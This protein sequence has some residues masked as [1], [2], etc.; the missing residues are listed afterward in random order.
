MN[1]F[2]CTDEVASFLSLKYLDK[3]VKVLIFIW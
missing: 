2:I 3:I 1:T